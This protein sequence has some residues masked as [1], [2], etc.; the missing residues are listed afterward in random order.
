VGR[1]RHAE[2]STDLDWRTILG[3]PVAVLGLFFALSLVRST[4]TTLT[5]IVIGTVLAVALDPVV[6][7]VQSGLRVRR[8]VAVGI[9]GAFVVSLAVVVVVFLG[10]PALREAQQFS[11][12]LPTV[13]DRLGELPVVG[14]RLQE[15]NAPER[16]QQFI[17]GLPGR[18]STDDGPLVRLLENIVGGAMA[19]FSTVLITIVLLLDGHRLVQGI[20][21]LV[22][23]NRRH[24]FD[25][26]ADILSRTIGRYFAGSLFVAVLSGLAMLVTGLVLGVPLA[27]VAAIWATLTNL[28]PQIGGF[29]GGSFFVLLGFADSPRTG[30][31]CLAYFLIWQQIENHV[32]QPLIVGEAVDLSPPATMMAALIGGASAGVPGALVA[33]PLLG[34]SKA[35]W[36]ARRDPAGKTSDAELASEASADS[37]QADADQGAGSVEV[38]E[39]P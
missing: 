37:E 38:S 32:I 6:D 39:S 28:I 17:E 14:H 31:I 35:I 2:Q 29:L 15:A 18:F 21:R 24:T 25:D 27:P 36:L 10:P 5:W 13:V 33:V 20:R 30:I 8:S 22:P 7:R 9:V 34:A 11:Q 16:L 1:L 3:V 12:D 23:T 26:V 4:R 19:A